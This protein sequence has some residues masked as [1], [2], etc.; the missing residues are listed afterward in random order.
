MG[1]P[2]N[3]SDLYWHRSGCCTYHHCTYNLC[4][5]A[6]KGITPLLEKERIISHLA[7]TRKQGPGE[8][9]TMGR[10]HLAWTAQSVIFMGLL[11]PH[12]IS[13]NLHL[14]WYNWLVGCF[15]VFFVTFQKILF[16]SGPCWSP[17][18]NLHKGLGLGSGLGR[19]IKKCWAL[20]EFSNYE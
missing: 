14:I 13:V 18:T 9:Q 10:Q 19:L 16:L 4:R 7:W 5:R 3:E 17:S 1:E 2:E 8:V 6:K 11:V 20:V 15:G 12:F